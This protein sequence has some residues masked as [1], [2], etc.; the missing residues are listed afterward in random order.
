MSIDSVVRGDWGS[1]SPSSLNRRSSVREIG[2]TADVRS[3]GL[4]VGK[5]I[6][7]FFWK[8]EEEEEEEERKRCSISFNSAHLTAAPFPVRWEGDSFLALYLIDR[9]T[10]LAVITFHDRKSGSQHTHGW[11]ISESSGMSRTKTVTSPRYETGAH[12]LDQG[13]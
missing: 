8:E 7:Y 9:A 13:T 4:G 3:A 1:I 5:S 12:W 10:L 6:F 11:F 2:S